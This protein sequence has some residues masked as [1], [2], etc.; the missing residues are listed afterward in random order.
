MS[1]SYQ[2]LISIFG[3]YIAWVCMLALGSYLF[4]RNE[5]LGGI[6]LGLTG[7]LI[8]IVLPYH[9][10]R[11]GVISYRFFPEKTKVW[12]IGGLSL[13]FFIFY[14]VVYPS[15]FLGSQ[16]TERFF[17][18]PPS[19]EVGLATFVF[20]LA[21]AIAYTLVFWGGLLFAI[22]Q[23]SNKFVAVIV[24]SLLFS[25]YHIS[26]FPFA[27]MTF[28]FFLEMFVGAVILTSFTLFV[29]CVVP[30]LIVAQIEQFFYFSTRQDNP[31]SEPGQAFM[32]IF[33]I[34]VFLGGYW[35]F[36]RRKSKIFS[37]A[38]SREM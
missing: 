9:L 13:L 24:T 20:L 33:L 11:V 35:L 26:Q 34:L 23:V 6:V 4:V 5:P 12:R 21:S 18:S 38:A 15:S 25:F 28:E 36:S 37:I 19:L 30:T 17:Q 22:T 31:F 27:P 3:V 1:K 32:E 16:T 14:L 7:I 8:G 2:S 10:W 29:D